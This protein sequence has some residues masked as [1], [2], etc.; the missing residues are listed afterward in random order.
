VYTVLLGDAVQAPLTG[1]CCGTPYSLSCSNLEWVEVTT[2]CL[3]AGCLC[4]F[5][6]LSLLKV[7]RWWHAMC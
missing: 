3:Q 6:L 4:C 7:L 1:N 2:G 5:L